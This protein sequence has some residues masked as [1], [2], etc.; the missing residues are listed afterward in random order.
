MSEEIRAKASSSGSMLNNPRVRA[1]LYQALLLFGLGYFFYSIVSNAL[2]NMEARGI[3]SGFDFLF[4]A[5]GFDILMTLVPYSAT[6]TYGMT[7]VVGLLNTILVSIVGIFF[8]TVLGFLIGVAYFSN[9]WLIK[10]LSVVYVET[11]RNI[12]LLLQVFFWYFAVLASLPSARE[13][14]SLGEVIFLNVRGLYLPDLVGGAGSSI[15]YGSIVVAIAAIVFLKKWA[16]KR[17]DDTGEQFP[18]ALTSL[19]ILLGLPLITLFIMGVP[20]TWDF[21]E[22]KGFN[23]RGG[24]TVIPELMALTIALSVYTGAFIAEAV[25]AGVQSVPHGQTE[26]ARSIG[27]RENRIMSL[28]IVPQAMRV[29]VPLLNSEYQ[30]LVKNSTLATAI[31]YPDLFTVFV[32]TSLNQTGQAIEIVFMTMAVYFVINMTI[33][34]LMNRFNASVALVERK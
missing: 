34:F 20:F 4:T 32:G 10:R 6:S 18:V 13:S 26:A 33:S 28:I 14:L 12:P 24:I 17:Q 2:N 5:S 8:A 11:F 16:K 30:S 9:N 1:I 15:V 31:G 29:I 3:K 21:P 19:G 27:L 23:F 7:F 22:L 25:R